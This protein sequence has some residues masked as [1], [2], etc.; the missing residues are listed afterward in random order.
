M[1]EGA[2]QPPQRSRHPLVERLSD[3]ALLPAGLVPARLLGAACASKHLPLA[4]ARSPSNC[5]SKRR[6]PGKCGRPA[7]GYPHPSWPAGIRSQAGLANDGLNANPVL[8]V[9]DHTPTIR[10][11]SP[12]AQEVTTSRPRAPLARHAAGGRRYFP[13]AGRVGWPAMV[14][15]QGLQNLRNPLLTP[16]GPAVDCQE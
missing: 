16:R 2:Q 3:I 15:R 9:V 7:R 12:H 10:G 13:E 6:T 4:A 8:Q 11:S 14:A 1:A 5:A